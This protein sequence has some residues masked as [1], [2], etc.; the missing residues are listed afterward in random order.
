MFQYLEETISRCFNHVFK[1]VCMLGVKLICSS[2]FDVVSPKIS[3]NPK[4]YLFFKVTFQYYNTIYCSFKL[5]F[6]IKSYESN[7]VKYI[8]LVKNCID[9]ID[10][11]PIDAHIPQDQQIPLYDRKTNTMWNV[12][13]ACS[14]DMRFTSVKSGWEGIADDSRVLLECISNPGNKFSLPTGVDVSSMLYVFICVM[15]NRSMCGGVGVVFLSRSHN[16][17]IMGVDG[18]RYEVNVWLLACVGVVRTLSL[19]DVKDMRI[20]LTAMEFVS[21]YMLKKEPK[22]GSCVGDLIKD[23]MAL[24]GVKNRMSEMRKTGIG[25]KRK[26]GDEFIESSGSVAIINVPVPDV[27]T[28]SSE[29]VA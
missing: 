2:N 27:G 1:K 9:A 6:S 8:F 16:H 10:E 24:D 28:A 29:D 23:N 17:V 22:N 19:L 25:E 12:M 21:I 13:C 7:Y 15:Y 5:F 20:T 4:Y 11:T 14:F 26:T 3:F 18:R